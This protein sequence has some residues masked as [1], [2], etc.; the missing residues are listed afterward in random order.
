MG[1]TKSEATSKDTASSGRAGPHE[2]RLPPGS[3]LSLLHRAAWK[4]A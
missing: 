3:T 2:V 4:N 1:S